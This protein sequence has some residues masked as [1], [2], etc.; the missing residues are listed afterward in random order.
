MFEGP[1]AGAGST[2]E[3]GLQSGLGSLAYP[4]PDQRGRWGFQLD[5]GLHQ[6]PD[7]ERLQGLLRAYAPWHE[8]PPSEVEWS[9]VTHFERRLARRFGS[10]R[11]W[12]AGDSAHIT[13]PFGGQSMN[14]GL[15]EA[16]DLV[17]LMA[18]CLQNGQA[19]ASLE[20]LGATREREWQKLLG[21]HVL[22][23]ASPSAPAWLREQARRILPALPVSG[24]DLQAVL[25]QLGVTVR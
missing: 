6:A 7:L 10:G 22:F 19:V 14:G 9:A 2:L 11:V 24:S 3:L 18:G 23:E 8:A 15:T 21:F 1:R 5:S 17:A 20:Q 25:R 13:S 12:L 16:H 4:L